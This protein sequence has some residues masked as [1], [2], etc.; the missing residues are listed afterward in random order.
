MS[1]MAAQEVF[2]VRYRRALLAHVNQETEEGLLDGLELGRMALTEGYGLLELLATHHKI[3]Y[4]LIEPEIWSFQDR[5][6][7]ANDFLAQ[8][9][10]PFEMAHRG[11]RDVVH[12]LRAANEELEKRVASVLE[13]ERSRQAEL[14]R[15]ARLTT[16]GA[17]T[18]SIAHEVNQPLAAI[19]AHANAG[20]RWLQREPPNFNEARTAFEHIVADGERARQVIDGV[21]AM[22]KSG[23]REKHPVPLNPII[24]EVLKLVR[25]EIIKHRVS[26]RIELPN[27]LPEVVADRT[28]LHQVFTNLIG[29]AIEA[30]Q[31][32]TNRERLLVIKSDVS[33]SGTVKIIVEDTGSGINPNDTERIFDAL[34]TTKTE[35]MGMGLS[36]CR[37][38]IEGHGGRLWATPRALHGSVFNVILPAATNKVTGT[39]PP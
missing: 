39:V 4:S 8:V 7:R 28:Q 29:N 16:M 22:F 9:V 10:A 25:G 35:G 20:L 17:L 14:A 2:E 32:V 23:D 31:P 34:F 18:A 19:A 15:V 5:L 3:V 1:T 37:S 24:E 12:Q 26:V 6:V 33:D 11:W 13:R 27:G 38:I 36:I 21:R 30:M